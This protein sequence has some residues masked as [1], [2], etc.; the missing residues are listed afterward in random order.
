MKKFY[1]VLVFIILP[2]YF[3]SAQTYPKY[4]LP[5]KTLDVVAVDDTLWV[6]TDAMVRKALKSNMENEVNDELIENLTKEVE[7]LKLQGQKKDTLITIV[8][9]DRDYY[10]KIWK[11]CSDDVDK[12][13]NIAKK[14]KSKTRIAII[15]GAS[16]TVIAFFAGAFILPF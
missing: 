15:V 14:S 2:F 13:G 8:E 4:V 1:L 9:Q 16:T 10:Q 12:L 5:G 3:V 11:E 7:I 6:L